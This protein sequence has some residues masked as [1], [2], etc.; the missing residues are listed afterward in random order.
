M[1]ALLVGAG[2]GG[3][4]DGWSMAGA[5]DELGGAAAAAAA[6]SAAAALA[7]ALAA[8][9]MG[10]CCWRRLDI[11]CVALS[12]NLVTQHRLA[13]GPHCKHKGVDGHALVGCS[14]FVQGGKAAC[15]SS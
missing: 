10:L 15:V 6:A 11:Q 7:S 3:W 4:L 9:V 1:A 5:P 13:Q 8:Q 14:M 12:Q 2:I